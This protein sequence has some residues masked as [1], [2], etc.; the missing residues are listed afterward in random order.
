M[1][2]ICLTDVCFSF[3]M[4]KQWLFYTL[5]RFAKKLSFGHF[6]H[7][8]A[9]C[10]AVLARQLLDILKMSFGLL[11]KNNTQNKIKTTH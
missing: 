4:S 1:I 2:L 6:E 10:L 7:V 9:R 11:V 3:K 8:S 5:F